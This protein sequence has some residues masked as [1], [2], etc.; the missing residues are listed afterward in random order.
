MIIRWIKHILFTIRPSAC[1]MVSIFVLVAYRPS[2]QEFRTGIVLGICAFFGSAFCFLVND[3]FDRRK[4]L[5][6]NTKRP[7]ANGALPLSIAWI[8]TSILLLVYLS[9]A[10][11]L[12]WVIL[13]LALFSI[14][15][16]L[17]YS[18]IN[19][20]KGIWANLIVAFCASGAIWGIA[21]IREF[22]ITLFYL[23]LMVFFLVLAREILLD[24]LDIN[25]D[26][27]IGKRSIPII[28]DSKSTFRILVFIL[29]IPSLMIAL[30][31]ILVP[32]KIQ[33]WILLALALP[34]IWIP[35]FRIS[36]DQAKQKILFN[37][38]FSH[39]TFA[40][41]TLSIVFR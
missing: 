31:P 39:V 10:F 30:A 1:L 13:A 20:S 38:R 27:A 33:A 15:I 40:L 36:K 5:L 22:E 34:A 12:G 2:Q 26:Q 11:Y 35:L 7:I 17:I 23:A 37:I 24:W 25:G 41:I 32:I 6:N 29:T 4:D 21:I 18:P 16:F 9:M 14:A 3:I 19:N 28:F 8:A